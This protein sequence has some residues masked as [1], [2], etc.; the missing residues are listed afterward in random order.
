VLHYT[1]LNIIASDKHSSLLGLLVSRK[2]NEVLGFTTSKYA[3]W[4]Q[5]PFSVLGCGYLNVVE[6]SCHGQTLEVVRI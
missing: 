2:E 4:C 6:Y 5:I 3:P 1:S